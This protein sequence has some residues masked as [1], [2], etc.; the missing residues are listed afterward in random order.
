MEREAALQTKALAPP[1]IDPPPLSLEVWQ[2]PDLEPGGPSFPFLPGESRGVSRSIGDVISGHLVDSATIPIPHPHLKVLPIQ[3]GRGLIYTSHAMLELI[4]FAAAHVHEIYPGSIAYL[5]NFSARGGGDIPWS[6]SHNSGRDGDIAFYALDGEGN[7]AVLPTLLP[8]DEEGKFVGE[9]GSPYE[10]QAYYFDVERNWR[11]VEGLILADGTPMQFIFISN[12]LRRM[13]LAEGRRVGATRGVLAQAEALLVQPGGALPHDD[14]FHLRIHCGAIDVGSGCVES[15][16]RGP[17]FDA[18]VRELRLT[19]AAAQGALTEEDPS[20]R[21]AGVQ[22]LELLGARQSAP[23]LIARLDDD[24]PR[25]RAAAARALSTLGTGAA[26]VARR[27][28]AEEEPQVIAEFIE[29][30]GRL[31]GAQAVGTLSALLAAPRPLAL[32]G[33]G[34]LDARI[35]ACDALARLEDPRPVEALIALLDDENPHVRIQGA[36]TLRVLTNHSFDH[37]WRALE[38]AQ[39]SA[40]I[41]Q[42][43]TWFEGHRSLS[44]DEWLARGFQGIGLDVPAL[45]ARHVWEISRAITE[46]DHLSYN[47]QRVMMRLSGRQPASLSWSK[48]DASFYW[49]RWFER[50]H[51]Q[52]GSPPPPPELSTL[53]ASP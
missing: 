14:H 42:W 25:V 1:I 52:Y 45:H 53:I 36:R 5:G 20:L 26:D 48:E 8:F 46:A 49:R 44:R 19:I 31:G 2:M 37:D 40:A 7:P 50:R 27:L 29:S 38:G 13:L 4:T 41:S 18:H 16:R 22:R 24:D 21:L 12:P 17:R 23:R 11:F 15:G 3:L 33:L 9:E 6:V 47:A 34:I 51:R 43:A 28:S 30:L 32:P 10:G 39:R 35:L